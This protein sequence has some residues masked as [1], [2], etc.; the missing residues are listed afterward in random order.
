MTR[1]VITVKPDLSIQELSQLFIE[2]S[3]NG[4][5]V[6]NDSGRVIGV[7]TEKDL[8]D[9]NKQLHMPTVI[10]LF[11]AVI[12]LES[13]DKFEQEV[14]KFTGTKVEDIYSSEVYSVLPDTPIS[15]V[16]T[17]MADKDIH[18]LPVLD[19]DKLVGILGK[20]DIIRGMSMG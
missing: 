15:D 14:K 19:G 8:I 18:T 9:Q 3:K 10:A 5:P 4:F 13:A 7:V 11:D 6:V 2:H 12:Y 20:T 16:A 17:L 1:H